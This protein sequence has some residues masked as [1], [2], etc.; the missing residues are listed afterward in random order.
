MY[1]DI[2]ITVF[3]NIEI[4]T[5]KAT[6]L[7]FMSKSKGACKRWLVE[8]WVVVVDH[9]VRGAGTSVFMLTWF[10]AQKVSVDCSSSE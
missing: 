5:T 9:V 4:S 2:R 1:R 6:S 7:T 3:K 8:G 10:W